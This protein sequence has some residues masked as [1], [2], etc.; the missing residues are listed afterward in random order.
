[1]LNVPPDRLA[2]AD[3]LRLVDQKIGEHR[4][5]EYKRR[6]PGQ[7]ERDRREFLADASSFANAGGGYI[8]YGVEEEKDAQG[9]GTGIPA[10]AP[11]LAGANPDLELRRLD[12]MLRDGVAPRIPGAHPVAVPGLPSGLVIALYVPRSFAAPHMVTFR[13]AS[14]FY[15]RG[16]AGRYE[17]NLDQLRAAFVASET[18]VEKLRALRAER[19]GR[20]IARDTPVPLSDGPV[21]TVLVAPLPIAGS[22]LGVDLT[23]VTIDDHTF[24]KLLQPMESTSWNHRRNFDG[25]VLHNSSAGDARA[26]TQLFRSGAIES[27][28]V[29]RP[30]EAIRWIACEKITIEAC[31]N[32]FQVYETLALDTPVFAMLSLIGA[33]GSGFFVDPSRFESARDFDRDEYVLP[34]VEIFPGSVATDLRPVFDI[35]WQSVGL[36][37]ALSYN[38][39][40][41]WS[42]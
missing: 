41:N 38:S 20:L 36:F 37:G 31:E 9:H 5:I 8:L 13:G 11:G 26:Y 22:A 6:L 29:L 39:A 17:L 27:V 16:A 42:P 7:G 1:M 10:D 28:R 25:I 40:G 12:Q 21:L 4:T 14:K 30:D 3:I 18:V 23:Q 19:L 35:V 33:K 24:M 34:E 2:A 15:A 32:A